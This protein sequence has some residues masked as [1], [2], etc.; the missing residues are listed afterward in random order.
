MRVTKTKLS[1]SVIGFVYSKIA[2]R[3]YKKLKPEWNYYYYY[4]SSSELLRI[5]KIRDYNAHKRYY[6]DTRLSYYRL[7]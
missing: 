1:F 2:D 3:N 7:I 5:S 6:I 4:S